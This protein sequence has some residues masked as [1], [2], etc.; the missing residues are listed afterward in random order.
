MAKS[1]Q[2]L[3][4]AL[5]DHVNLEGSE[6]DQWY[7]DAAKDGKARLFDQH[8]IVQDKHWY[9]LEEAASPEEAQAVVKHFRD[10]KMD[11]AKAAPE[12]GGAEVYA[13]RKRDDT[14]PAGPQKPALI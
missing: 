4:G 12:A 1:S 8:G 11:G 6:Y 3:I 13:F 7:V 5:K 9:F 14:T 10:N 2:E